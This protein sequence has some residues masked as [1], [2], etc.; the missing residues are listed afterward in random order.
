MQ[1]AKRTGLSQSSIGRILRCDVNPSASALNSIASAF[2][3]PIDD[4]YLPPDAFAAKH[5]SEHQKGLKDIQGALDALAVSADR[6]AKGLVPL[7]T[8]KQVA[9]GGTQ[10]PIDWVMCPLP[11]NTKTYALNVQGLGMFNP[12]GFLSFQEGDRI[13]VDRGVQPVHRS[14]VVV[15]IGNSEEASLRQII[16][17]DGQWLLLQLNPSWPN[18]VAPLATDDD[19]IL[20]TVIAKVQTFVSGAGDAAASQGTEL[21]H[22]K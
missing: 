16:A 10:E 2:G 5:M 17:E 6:L 8:W 22:P 11:H 7:F 18:R 20:G 13:F 14:I 19:A 9:L 1:I 15:R 4:L 12:A 3:V 21:P